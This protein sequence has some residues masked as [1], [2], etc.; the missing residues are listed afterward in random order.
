M[1][2]ITQT[3]ASAL[4]REAPE[5][6]IPFNGG[7]IAYRRVGT[8]P[9]VLFVHGWPM[10]GATWRKLLPYLAPHVT[11]HVIDLVGAG[12]SQ[13]TRQTPIGLDNHVAAVRHVVDVLGLQSVS[14]V[15]QDSGG[16]IARHAM[17]GD[18]RV[19]S[20]AFVNTEQPQGIT[21]R[22]RQFL[23]L[24]FVPGFEHIL[25]WLGMQ[26]RIRRNKLVLGDCFADL[27]LLD[28]EFEEF[29]MA[30]IRDNR[31]LRWAMGKLLRS[32]EMSYIDG[33]A[34]VHARIEAPVQ[35][36]WGEDDAFFPID[37]TREMVSTFPDAHLHVIPRGRLMLHEEFP[38]EVASAFLPTLLGERGEERSA[39]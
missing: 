14:L 8:G 11:C 5:R 39:A 34:D 22:F 16:L 7:A 4:F 13:F 20:M 33:L 12:D 35:L 15:G 24:G 6:L 31:E 32:F 3:Q 18:A 38:E 1:T 36:V 30:P 29:F 25:A 19:R 9:D 21:F 2:R 27:S 26:R 28:G 37:W 23:W 10:S 17:A